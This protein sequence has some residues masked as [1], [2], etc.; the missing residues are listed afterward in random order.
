MFPPVLNP[1]YSVCSPRTGLN[2]LSG[3][4]KEQWSIPMSHML[5]TLLQIFWFQS[6][7]PDQDGAHK[8]AITNCL[9][10][11]KANKGSSFSAA[12]WSVFPSSPAACHCDA[13]SFLVM[14][15]VRLCSSCSRIR[16][17][18]RVPTGMRFGGKK[19][20]WGNSWHPMK[21]RL[22]YD[23]VIWAVFDNAAKKVQEKLESSPTAAL[24][25][26]LKAVSCL[27]ENKV[28]RFLVV[29]TEYR[30]FRC[31]FPFVAFVTVWYYCR[32]LNH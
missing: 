24:L 20:Q 5:D 32:S 30:T 2:K 4:R 23:N 25:S 12:C 8:S 26:K 19:V 16:A 15:G 27:Y 14:D 22:L 10:R 31:T 9:V 1:L 13:V 6:T 11:H 21:P 18:P 29:F 3:W 17:L 28:S 7:A